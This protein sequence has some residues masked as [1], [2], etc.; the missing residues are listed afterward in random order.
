MGKGDQKTKKGKIFRNSYG[1]RRPKKKQRIKKKS[2]AKNPQEN[3]PELQEE[4]TGINIEKTQEDKK[5][6]E[7]VKESQDNA[8]TEKT[9]EGD[10][11]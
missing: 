1:V 5:Q 9:E 3:A 11:Q 4:M 6:A 7:K 8:G 10:K 2:L